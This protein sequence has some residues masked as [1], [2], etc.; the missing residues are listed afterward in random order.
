MNHI[1]H[2]INQNTK[3]EFITFH[4]QGELYGIH[5]A[6]AKEIIKVPRITKVFHARAPIFGMINHRGDIY[7]VFDVRPLLGFEPSSVSDESRIIIMK[8]K[9]GL[10]FGF[11][12]DSIWDIAHGEEF[13]ET[14][15]PDSEAD[16][17]ISGIFR[18]RNE[19]IS[20]IDMQRIYEL[21]K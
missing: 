11:I 14:K 18:T 20:I 19:S 10:R 7:V 4:L 21:T 13:H 3:W 5:I 1:N 17:L 2:E 16:R 6:D 8:D 9:I 12:V 15:Q